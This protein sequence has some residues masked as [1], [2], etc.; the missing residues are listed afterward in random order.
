MIGKISSTYVIPGFVGILILCGTFVIF[1][2]FLQYQ[3]EI[4]ES[5]KE[6]FTGII[7]NTISR[8]EGRI[9]TIASSIVALYANS[10]EVEKA[11]FDNFVEMILGSNQEIYNVFTLSNNT[12]TQSFPIKEYVGKDFDVTF[13]TYPT[14]IAGKNAMTVEFDINDELLLIIA[15]PFDYFVQ[16][17]VVTSNNYKIVLLSPIDDNVK[18]YSIEKSSDGIKYD[19]IFSEEEL[20]DSITI[21]HQTSLFGHKIKQ[22]YDLKYIIWDSSFGRQAAEQAVIVGVGTSLSIIIPILLIRSNLL[23]NQ[24]REKSEILQK[25][26]QELVN[27]EKSKDEFVTMI[28]HDLK[29]PLVPI[30]AYAEILLMQSLGSLNEKQI[31]RLQSI[32]NNALVLQKMIRDLLDANKLG[33]G[34]L[35][36]DIQVHS[37]GEIIKNEISGLDLEFQKKGITTTFEVSED[38]SCEC[39][40][41]RIGQVINNILLNAIDFVNENTGKIEVSLKKDARIAT[42]LVKDNGVGIAKDKIDSVFVKFYQI[43]PNKQRKYGGT[44]LGLSVCKGIIENHNGRIWAESEGEGMGTEIHIEIPLKQPAGFPQNR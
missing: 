15:V 28:V 14:Q 26:N 25:L 23:R 5:N 29:N 35:R 21:E 18:L 1:Y 42:I 38:V 33:L 22:N 34:K 11:E 9:E 4:R 2:Q 17:G 39:D 6:K 7:E 32:R 37:L 13:P 10:N 36:L 43:Q 19:T 20:R 40:R 27:V 41:S 24:L 3:N 30:Q 12:I 8:R 16:E 31:Q 44:G